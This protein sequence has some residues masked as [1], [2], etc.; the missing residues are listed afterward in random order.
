MKKGA[1][2]KIRPFKSA[3]IESQ[4]RNN[5]TKAKEKSWDNLPE[6][7]SRSSSPRKLKSRP[8]LLSDEELY[9]YRFC[10]CGKGKK[11]KNFNFFEKVIKN[12]IFFSI[13]F[14]MNIILMWVL[15]MKGEKIKENLLVLKFF[16][17]FFVMNIS[18]FC[19]NIS[20]LGNFKGLIESKQAKKKLKK[21][22][23][24][25]IANFTFML[26][27]QIILLIEFL[28]FSILTILVIMGKYFLIENKS[29]VEKKITG[30]WVKVFYISILGI[31][32]FFCILNF[33]NLK[34]IVKSFDVL[35]EIRIEL[36]EKRSKKLNLEELE[37]SIF[38]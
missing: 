23:C 37:D 9:D 22:S 30:I 5:F 32:G 13:F 31:I 1:R 34:M 28:I 2:F 20:A 4:V 38:N 12:Q 35:S 36:D 25:I 19:V 6:I 21:I 27:N 8:K 16:I 10:L 7:Q 18:N 15:L 33:M 14:L 29:G 26:V 24:K 17:F 11:M 3:R